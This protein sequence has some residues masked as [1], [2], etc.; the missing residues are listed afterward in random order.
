[1]AAATDDEEMRAA[2]A[3]TRKRK[4]VS[5]FLVSLVSN[6]SGRFLGCVFDS[7]PRGGNS[8]HC[9]QDSGFL[10]SPGPSPLVRHPPRCVPDGGAE[11]E[12][13]HQSPADLP[14]TEL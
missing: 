1:M 9:F 6:P 5:V 13:S 11:D 4:D 8:C 14:Q 2:Y 3:V 7:D 10:S 12:V